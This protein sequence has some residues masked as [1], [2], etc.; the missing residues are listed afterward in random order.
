MV[1]I[2][3]AVGV[4]DAVVG[5]GGGDANGHGVA[6]AGGD[7]APASDYAADGAEGDLV[8]LDYYYFSECLRD[9]LIAN[10]G[11]WN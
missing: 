3:A 8:V 2:D 5:D 7:G 10:Y 9:L 11:C 1:V 4:A 6:A